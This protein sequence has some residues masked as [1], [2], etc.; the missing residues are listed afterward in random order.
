MQPWLRRPCKLFRPDP[1]YLKGE[2]RI[3]RY[4]QGLALRR[5]DELCEK[6]YDETPAGLAGY[7]DL[8]ESDE[9]TRALSPL[10]EPPMLAERNLRRGAQFMTSHDRTVY[11]ADFGPR[12]TALVADIRTFDSDKQPH[13]MNIMPFTMAADVPMSLGST[14]SD[15]A[16]KASM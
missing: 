8:G 12:T 13:T 10:C 7:C 14:P 6:G 16:L 4:L 1:D 5:R 9:E 3:R 2:N 15:A 11:E